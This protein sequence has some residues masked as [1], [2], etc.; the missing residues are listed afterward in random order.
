VPA[1][2]NR[3]RDRRTV[4]ARR[5]QARSREGRRARAGSGVE[6]NTDSMGPCIKSRASFGTS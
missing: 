2:R 5:Q 1:E 4:S 6:R 3:R